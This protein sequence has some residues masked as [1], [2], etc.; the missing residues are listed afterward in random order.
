MLYL[1]A[2]IVIAE[3]ED[4]SMDSDDMMENIQILKNLELKDKIELY[5][6]KASKLHTEFKTNLKKT[7]AVNAFLDQR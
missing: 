2:A 4:R 3:W 1:C 5:V 7:R 6:S